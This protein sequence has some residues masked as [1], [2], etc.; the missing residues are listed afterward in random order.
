M[1]RIVRHCLIL[2][3]ATLTILPLAS[4]AS[5]KSSY[6]AVLLVRSNTDSEA[7]M[8]FMEFEGSMVFK[9]KCEDA[10]S[11]SWTAELESG[12]VTVYFDDG[13]GRTELFKAGD[14]ASLRGE[15]SDLEQGTVYIIVETNGKCKEGSFTFLVD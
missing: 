4:C 12:D 7:S 9:L 1:K 11:I 13:R 14:G 2:L 8:S 15:S 5:Y 10:D 3:L 6:R